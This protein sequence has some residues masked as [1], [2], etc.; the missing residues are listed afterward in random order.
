M[1]NNK[2]SSVEWLFEQLKNHLDMP[3]NHANEILS[4]A[5]YINKEQNIE[6]YKRGDGQYD[7][8][9]DKLAEQYYNETYGGGNNEQ[10]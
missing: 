10:R 3:F 1:S 8:V 9:A 7:K 6:A 2:Q 5:K 4:Q